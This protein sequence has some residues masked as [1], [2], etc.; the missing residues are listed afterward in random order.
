MR[1]LAWALMATLLAP[2]GPPPQPGRDVPASPPGRQQGLTRPD[3]DDAYRSALE[4]L[5]AG[6]IEESRARIASLASSPPEDPL[7]RYL[8]AL[9]FC[10]KVEQGGESTAFDKDLEAKVEAA[11]ASAEAA[12]QKDPQDLRALFARGAAHGVRSRFH[13]FRLHRTE[14]ARAA[15][16]MREDLRELVRRLPSSKD[17]LLG[18]GLYDYYADVL[19]KLVKVMRFLARIPGGDRKRGLASIEEAGKGSLFHDREA[20][21]QLYEIYAFYER[22]PDRALKEIRALSERYPDWPLWPL[23]LIEHLR[24]RMGLYKESADVARTLL[25]RGRRGHPNYAGVSLAL[26]RLSLAE[27]LLLDL[28]PS[29][30][31]QELASLVGP[32]ATEEARVTAKAHLLLGRSLELEGEG[33][34]ARNHYR[35][36]ATS[37]DKEIRDRA[38]AALS[39]P[40]SSEEARAWPLIAQARRLREQERVKESAEFYGRALLAWPD[41]A[42]A[43]LRTAEEEIKRGHAESARRV[44]TR[45]ARMEIHH[46]PWIGAWSRLLLARLH[47]LAGERGAALKVYQQVYE[48]PCGQDELREG[49]GEGLKRPFALEDASKASDLANIPFQL[50]F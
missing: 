40:L 43:A 20:Q 17:A 35:K 42:E 28:R 16:R 1:S 50:V 6:D 37:T 29:E 8:E 19:P 5:Y 26:A 34:R 47:D 9:V 30:A 31:R 33:E 27:S 4:S 39:W 11:L 10:W 44:V 48:E 24:D 22:R 25:E 36:A 7:G 38:R 15:V 41:S 32:G 14:A 21:I 46:P 13:L 3:R 45:L 12:L 2:L 18:L 49:A 23:K